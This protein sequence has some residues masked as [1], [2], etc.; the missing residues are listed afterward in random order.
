MTD[1]AADSE[2]KFQRRNFGVAIFLS[3]VENS[4]YQAFTQDFHKQDGGQV[5]HESCLN[6]TLSTG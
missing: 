1:K 6:D 2:A 4:N 3:V 5:N